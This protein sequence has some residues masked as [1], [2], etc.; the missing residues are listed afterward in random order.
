ML[1]TSDTYVLITFDSGE[2]YVLPFIQGL[3]IDFRAGGY[4]Q[5]YIP[6]F[7]IPFKDFDVEEEYHEDDEDPSDEFSD[8]A[9]EDEEEMDPL[10][11]KLIYKRWKDLAQQTDWRTNIHPQFDCLDPSDDF[12]SHRQAESSPIAIYSIDGNFDEF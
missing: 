4:V 10:W 1:W 7:Q 9:P 3:D 8:E 11:E 6:P 2:G 5:L 12:P